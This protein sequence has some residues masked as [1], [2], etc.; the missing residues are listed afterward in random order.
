M[1]NN[2]DNQI[3]LARISNDLAQIAVRLGNLNHDKDE[4]LTG[5]QKNVSTAVNALDAYVTELVSRYKSS[6]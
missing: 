5:A 6:T 2:S 1:K 4:I 3:I